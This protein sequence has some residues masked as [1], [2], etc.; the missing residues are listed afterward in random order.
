MSDSRLY[1][2]E[3]RAPQRD[4]RPAAVPRQAE[5]RQAAPPTEGP[6]PGEGRLHRRR[7][8]SDVLFIPKGVIPP[9]LSYEWKRA[10]VFNQP[11]TEHQ[12]GLRENHWT[13]VPADRHPELAAAGETVIRRG[14]LLL[15]QRP[16]YLTDEAQMEDINEALRPIAV[17]EEKLYGTPEGEF[18]RNHPSVRQHARINQQFAPGPPINDDGTLGSEP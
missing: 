10:S 1:E 8:T 9:G 3:A 16:K 15:M 11:D 17:T 4:T 18:T 12:I 2:S 13:A 6:V 5:T 7:H 14:G